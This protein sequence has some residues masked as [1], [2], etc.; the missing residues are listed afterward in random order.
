LIP[1]WA[2]TVE[3]A[4]DCVRGSAE[5]AQL[6]H[7]AAFQERVAEPSEAGG[8]HHVVARAAFGG[9]PGPIGDTLGH[10]F[11]A[12]HDCACTSA[13]DSGIL[14]QEGSSNNIFNLGY[15]SIAVGTMVSRLKHAPT[16]LLSRVEWAI[17]PCP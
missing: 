13:E 14:S 12:R 5:G 7:V 4:D 1:S 6:E 11:G 8:A 16:R 9:V 3:A 10:A 2:G 17:L 15:T